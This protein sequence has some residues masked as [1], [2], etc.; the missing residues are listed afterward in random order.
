MKIAI[1]VTRQFYGPEYRKSLVPNQENGAPLLFSS[2]REAKAHIERLEA[3]T[4]HLSHNESGRPDYTPIPVAKL[5]KH[6]KP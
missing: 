6:L 4:Y 2:T 1:K 5:P 3:E